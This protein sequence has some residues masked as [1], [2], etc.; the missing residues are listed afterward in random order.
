MG[1]R[2]ALR[3]VVCFRN[4]AD[5]ILESW[6]GPGREPEGAELACLLREQGPPAWRPTLA[7]IPPGR[8][9]PLELFQG[10]RSDGCGGDARGQRPVLAVQTSVG[11]QRES[12]V[13]QL[14]LD[15]LQG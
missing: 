12:R 13:V 3:F 14:S 11:A 8:D 4:G 5:D 1:G 6:S 9:E 10:Q 2:T 15:I 7:L